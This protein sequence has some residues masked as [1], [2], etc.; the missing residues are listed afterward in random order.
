MQVGETHRGGDSAQV[1]VGKEEPLQSELLP[2]R[3]G[4]MVRRLQ[5]R[6]TVRARTA[7]ASVGHASGA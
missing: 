3:D 2:Q 7:P 1:V 5:R 6:R 4:R